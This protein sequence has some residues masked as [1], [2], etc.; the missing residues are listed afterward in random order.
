[1]PPDQRH[2]FSTRLAQLT[3]PELTIILHAAGRTIGLRHPCYHNSPEDHSPIACEQGRAL[4]FLP[5]S[6]RHVDATPNPTLVSKRVLALLDKKVFEAAAAA[7]DGMDH[8]GTPAA[9]LT[10]TNAATFASALPLPTFS[11][12]AAGLV[13][14]EKLAR[15]V[16]LNPA[17]V[18]PDLPPHHRAP[19]YQAIHDHL[20]A[21]ALDL[22]D[23]RHPATVA[24]FEIHT[25]GPPAARPP[26]RA[27]PAHAKFMRDEIAT[28]HTHGLIHSSSTPWAAPCFPVPKPRSDKLRLVIDY[29]ALNAQTRRDSFPIPHIQD[30]L[31]KVGQFRHWSKL[32]LKSGFWQVPLHPD[33]EQFTGVCTPDEL[34]V[35][36]RLPFGVRNGPPHFQRTMNEAIA[37][38]GL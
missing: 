7:F 1:M 34:F 12:D 18:N 35:W 2:Q 33:H 14:L 23:L 5:G 20:D 15:I 38:A 29:R 26:I 28:L 31:I 27:S 22:E 4:D 32:D 25:F 19:Y 3:L 13:K 24:P 30:V 37:A 10:A 6:F 9:P 21:F 8:L 17:I 11:T 36:R 16:A